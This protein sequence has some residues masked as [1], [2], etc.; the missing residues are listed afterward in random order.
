[1]TTAARAKGSP[2]DEIHARLALPRKARQPDFRA[3]P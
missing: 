2:M 1:L 3:P